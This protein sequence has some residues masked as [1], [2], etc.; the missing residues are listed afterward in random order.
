[1]TKIGKTKTTVQNG[2]G[3]LVSCIHNSSEPCFNPVKLKIIHPEPGQ[4]YGMGDCIS[5]T[6]RNTNNPPPSTFW[7]D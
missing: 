3:L 6:H 2:V 1:M 5:P 7:E 4:N